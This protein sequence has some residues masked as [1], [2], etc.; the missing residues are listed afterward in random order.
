D[1]PRRRRQRP[2]TGKVAA[3]QPEEQRGLRGRGEGRGGGLLLHHRPGDADTK[4]L[5]K[6]PEGPGGRGGDRQ[7]PGRRD[8]AL[9]AGVRRPGGQRPPP[10]AAGRDDGRP[11]L[12]RGRRVPGGGG[13]FGRAVPAGGGA[14]QEPAAVPL[15]AFVPGGGAVVVRRGGAAAGAGP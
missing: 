8:A 6:R 13:R 12:R 11:E 9:P 3:L 4:D 5:Q 2:A 14:D 10:G 15:L 1:D 7:R